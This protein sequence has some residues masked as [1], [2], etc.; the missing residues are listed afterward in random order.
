M[1]ELDNKFDAIDARK[2]GKQD[3][4]ADFE[5]KKEAQRAFY[6]FAVKDAKGQIDMRHP[7]NIQLLKDVQ[8][9]L[10][11]QD[12]ECYALTQSI[13][14]Q[15]Q[16][17]QSGTRQEV[18]KEQEQVE[19]QKFAQYFSIPAEKLQELTKTLKEW[20]L[21][22]DVLQLLEK[23]KKYIDENLVWLDSQ[24][25]Q[26][27]KQSIGLRT[28]SIWKIVGDLRK[29][30]SDMSQF[31]NNKWI[32]NEK[33]MEHFERVDKAILPSCI[34]YIKYSQKENRE[35]LIQTLTTKYPPWL[36]ARNK[37]QHEMDL[38]KYLDA[39]K[40]MLDSKLTD[41]WDFDKWWF[42][43]QF[44]FDER[45][46]ESEFYLNEIQT[47]KV[48]EF[49][50]LS[51]EDREI[52]R[53]AKLY[54]IAAVGV[55]IWL[56]SATWLAWPVAWTGGTLVSA[57]IDAADLFSSTEVLM[58]I[59]QG[60]G[61]VD[62]RYRMEKTLFDNFMAGLGIIPGISIAIKQQK[63]AKFLKKFSQ[64]EVTKAMWEIGEALKDWLK[65]RTKLAQELWYTTQDIKKYTS[66]SVEDMLK[67]VTKDEREKAAEIVLW[68]KLNIE[69]KE[70]I[71][72][73]HV[74]GRAPFT[75][76]DIKNKIS[77][78]TKNGV[79]KENERKRLLLKWVCW[80]QGDPYKL[81]PFLERYRKVLGD[82]VKF[83]DIVWRWLNALTIKWE[84]KKSLYKIPFEE[85]K[86]IQEVNAA[87]EKEAI[88]HSG[89]R[90]LVQP[91]WES[92]KLPRTV[93]VPKVSEIPKPPDVLYTMELIDAKSLSA[94]DLVRAR[95]DL[96]S[97]R[98]WL[99]KE[100]LDGMNDFA[101]RKYLEGR[102]WEKE[103][104]KLM[105]Q[106]KPEQIL[107]PRLNPVWGNQKLYDDFMKAKKYFEDNWLVHWDLH[108]GNVLIDKN[109]N[110]YIIDFGS[111]SGPESLFKRYNK[112]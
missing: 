17:L 37:Y 108:W 110:L 107:N 54:F 47:P 103:A 13:Q 74:V 20:G 69:Q 90:E 5:A 60:V 80:E 19:I 55:Q 25:L 6:Q 44:I 73:A 78:L 57:W 48:P 21:N 65:W 14:H 8:T 67:I 31:Q 27:V 30:E 77:I 93:N 23:Y 112:E 95:P 10:E 105:T 33:V 38:T 41:E 81:F 66:M 58:D 87:I 52:E 35:K 16:T 76:T 88:V 34:F 97:W 22:L 49:S 111:G 29:K 18:S 61:L 72:D 46:P 104:H 86:P 1:W 94:E 42:W 64:N 82:N 9:L 36:F 32:I 40:K 70:A 96:F 100:Q 45:F 106:F 53:K 2:D 91:G 84:V 101:I 43:T 92:W 102:Y 3:V 68:K 83:E 59:L 98:N 12:L 56:G 85:G 51:E 109:W 89:F 24:Y 11:R 62:P 71:W 63:I 7:S 99:S 26:K 28:L 4:W 50:I 79:F 15:M 39:T 75:Y